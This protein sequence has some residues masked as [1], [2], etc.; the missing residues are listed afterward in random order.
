VC[1]CLC[2]CRWNEALGI[3]TLAHRGKR[4]QKGGHFFSNKLDTG[5]GACSAGL[6]GG[7]DEW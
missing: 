1:L 6:G 5:A 4:I 3:E 7:L 2:V